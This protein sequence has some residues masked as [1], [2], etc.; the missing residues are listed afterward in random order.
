MSTNTNS[1]MEPVSL[2]DAEEIEEEIV[3]NMEEHPVV[4]SE[5]LELEVNHVNDTPTPKGMQCFIMKK[6]FQG[7]TLFLLHA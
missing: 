4:N 7:M 1:I 2:S 3:T 5:P 6:K